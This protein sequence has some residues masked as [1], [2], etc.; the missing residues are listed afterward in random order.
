MV[1]SKRLMKATYIEYSDTGSFSKLLLAYMAG[2]EVLA[3]FYGNK[4][5]LEGFGKQLLAKSNFPESRRQLLVAELKSQYGSLLEAAPHVLSNIESLQDQRTFTVT[6]GH[7]LNLFTGPLY[8]I[9]KIAT[10]IR[11]ARDLKAAYPDYHFVPVYWMATEDHDFAEINHTWLHGEKIAW[12][13]PAVAATGRMATRDIL[14]VVRKYQGALGL[15]GYAG[16]LAQWVEE[17]YAGQDNLADAT[18]L[19]VHR[20]FAHEGLVIMDADQASL[21]SEFLPIMSEDIRKGS[22]AAAISKSN[23]RLQ[24]LGFG[25][26]VNGR[27][28][29]F[30]YLTD[31]Y[32]ERIVAEDGE[33]QV[34]NQELRF[35]EAELET[36]LAEHPERFSPNVVM[37]PLYQEVILPNLAYIGGGAEIAYWLQLKGVFDH[38]QVPFP[39]LIPRNSAIITDRS[40]ADKLSRLH[41]DFRQV[42]RPTNVLQKEYV[43]R[44]SEHRLDLKDEWQELQAIFDKIKQR[45]SQIDTTLGPSTEAVEARLRRAMQNLEKKLLKADL[46]NHQDAV[47]QIERIKEK[48]FPGGGLQ[49]RKENFGL[50]YVRHGQELFSELIRLFDPLDF[51]FTVLYD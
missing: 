40:V 42:F 14:A 15:S 21:K 30:F 39:L 12:D 36:E 26:Q 16:E 24:E 7:Q 4:P 43:A 33:Y 27:P 46:R 19:L 50:Y 3:S 23:A 51:K 48:L 6:T 18:R 49:E 20:L 25:V 28:I 31:A 47:L 1:D 44:Q 2:D 10:A 9:F 8:F 32:R 41:L 34:W 11:L 5:T 37:R 45:A 35:S 38:Y 13:I 29:N 17:A 22:S